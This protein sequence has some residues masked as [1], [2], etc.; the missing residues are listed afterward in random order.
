MSGYCQFCRGNREEI[1]TH[2]E[3]EF[4]PTNKFITVFIFA[5]TFYPDLSSG[6]NLIIRT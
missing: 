3:Y 4:I 5:G 6:Q 2:E 1:N